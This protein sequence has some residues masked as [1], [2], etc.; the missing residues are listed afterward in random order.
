VTEDPTVPQQQFV[1]V[2]AGSERRVLVADDNV[3]AAATLAMLLQTLGYAVREVH[4]GEAA[5]TAA[6]EFKP[7]LAFLDIGM[8][9]L[10]GYQACRQIRA[11]PGGPAMRLVAVTGWG[12]AEDRNA[13]REAGFD[14]HLVKPVEP[15]EL[16]AVLGSAPTPSA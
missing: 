12:Q 15:G 1:D 11:L 14:T 10:N 16:A 5:V 13:A 8:P 4:D 7:H 3:D 9:G 6:A 2:P